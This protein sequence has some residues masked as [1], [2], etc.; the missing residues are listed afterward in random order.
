M[1]TIQDSRILIK[2]STVT[3]TVP[4]IPASNDHTDGSWLITDLYKGEFFINLA[5]SRVFMRDNSG[6]VELISTAVIFNSFIMRS[7]GPLGHRI[8]I[9]IGDD[10]AFS[11]EDLGV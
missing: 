4:T 3:T 6:I 7:T 1:P 11:Y 10:L 2:T 8:R 5:D 9:T